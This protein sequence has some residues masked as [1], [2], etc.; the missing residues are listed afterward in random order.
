MKN[1]IRKIENF[2]CEKCG[3]EVLGNGY[4]D[5][6]PKCLWGKHVDGDIPGDRKSSCRALMEPIGAELVRGDF[7]IRYKCTGC[8]HEFF[9]KIVDGDNRELLVELINGQGACG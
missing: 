1:F 9:V 6:C 7:K 8:K 4:T 3:E 5:H 2:I